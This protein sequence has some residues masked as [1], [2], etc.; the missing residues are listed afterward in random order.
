MPRMT[1]S[2]STTLDGVTTPHTTY[3]DGDSVDKKN[4]TVA[5]AKS[6]TLSTR[7]DNDTGELTMSGGH[8]ISTGDVIDVYWSGGSRVNMTV[9]TVAVNAVPIDGGSG[10]NLPVATTAITAMVRHEENFTV[11]GNDVVG[12]LL[13]S[14]VPATVTFAESD[15]T[16]V[17]GTPIRLTADDASTPRYNYV[18]HADKGTNPLAGGSV[19]TILLS[20]GSTSSVTSINTAVLYN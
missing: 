20:H 6:G 2:E 18:W 16:T 5:A 19:G 13:S 15:G 9:G 7:T 10:D 4:P 14:S 3:I 1:V 17:V 11:V 12:I 8:G